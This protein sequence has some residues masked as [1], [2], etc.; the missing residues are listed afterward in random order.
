MSPLAEEMA[1]VGEVEE[2]DETMLTL[3]GEETGSTLISFSFSFL[4][5]LIARLPKEG[6]FE[7]GVSSSSSEEMVIVERGD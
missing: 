7:I 4:T 5:L 3:A 6:I 1:L 2:D